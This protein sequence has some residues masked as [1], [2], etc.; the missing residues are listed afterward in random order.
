MA[1]PA[2]FLAGAS[3]AALAGLG[4]YIF[5]EADERQR[6]GARQ[7][8]SKPIAIP[9]P[10]SP[11]VA[12]GKIDEAAKHIG[13]GRPD[14][15][16]K[17]LERLRRERWDQ[18]SNRERYRIIANLGNAK[19]AQRETEDAAKFY[20]RTVEYQ[21]Q[22]EDARAY[23]ALGYLFLGERGKASQLSLKLCGDHPGLGRAHM[24][25]IRTEPDETPF[26]ELLASIPIAVQ[27]H[28]EVALALY[29]RAAVTGRLTDAEKI[30]RATELDEWPALPIA[31]GS[32]IPDLLT[33]PCSEMSG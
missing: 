31:L 28:P 22:D 14:L 18:L 32:V 15:T 1:E 7:A 29:E 5:G 12:H 24:I 10:T 2:L 6:K 25:R 11:L 17:L 3:T 33:Y 16:I 21:P 19:L 23:Q 27:G 9:V 30:I 26:D 20:I 4:R 8:A 13:E